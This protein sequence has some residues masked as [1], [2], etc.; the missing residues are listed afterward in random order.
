M[1]PR[2]LPAP[3]SHPSSWS[4]GLRPSWTESRLRLP[5]EVSAAHPACLRRP[6]HRQRVVPCPVGGRLGRLFVTSMGICVQVFVQKRCSFPSGIEPGAELLG[7]VA[8]M[9]RLLSF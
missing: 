2:R 7:R 4:P 1:T 6:R 3:G 8:A 5:S 9:F